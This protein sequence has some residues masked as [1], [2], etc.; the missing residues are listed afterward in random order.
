MEELISI[1]V[2]VY[3]V[4]EQYLR[5]CIES[6][7]RQTYRALEIIL[8][9][10]GSKDRSHFICD[11]YAAKDHRIKVI[12][13]NNEGLSAARNTGFYAATGKWLMF[14][15]GD[16]WIESN[17]CT[18]MLDAAHTFNV[19]VV[20][21][22]MYKS[23]E[24]VDVPYHYYIVPDK[25]Y[26]KNECK[27]LQEQILHFDSNIATAYCK[28]IDKKILDE[29]NIIHDATLKQG[30]EG[31][32]FNLRL[33]EK[34]QSAVFINKN[35]Y[36]Y[37]YNENSI[38]V[39]HS[40][41]NHMY[42]LKCFKKIREFIKQSC[43]NKNLEYWFY[44]RLL[45]V[46]ITTAISGY[47]SPSNRVPYKQKKIEYAKY[48]SNDLVQDA[49]SKNVVDGM[50]NSRKLVLFLINHKFYFLLN[51]LGIIRTIQRKLK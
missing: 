19:Q 7:I 46:I 34:I 22:G 15:D 5:N 40:V 29:E 48:L 39:K 45:Y 47:F 43:N 49:L 1:V 9:D 10:D 24:H 25:R 51:A 27:W 30:A 14:I 31:I 4:P 37:V 11:S 20:M 3:N 12:H 36:H 16:D 35:L 17:M 42:V 44:N 32:E 33:F 13:K 18:T 8:V 28:L 26:E 50:S 6:I 21:C 41:E 38:S 23:F 2:P